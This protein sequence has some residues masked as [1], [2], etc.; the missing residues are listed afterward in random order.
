MQR[1][2]ERLLHGF[3]GEAGVAERPPREPVQLAAVRRVDRADVVVRRQGASLIHNAW[4]IRTGRR[5]GSSPVH[6]KLR[7]ASAGSGT[8]KPRR[9][10]S[11]AAAEVSTAGTV[12]TSRQYTNAA[13]L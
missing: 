9:V 12:W 6:P 10:T 1:A 5:I 7:S 8:S 4:R 2:Q 13:A 11:A 3:L